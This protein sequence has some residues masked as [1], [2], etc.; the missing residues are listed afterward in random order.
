MHIRLVLVGLSG[1]GKSTLA[2]TIAAKLDWLAIDIDTAI[3]DRMGKSIPE[4]FASEGE[5]GFRQIE[6]EILA[7]SL[8]LDHVVIATGGGAVIREDV[9]TAEMLADSTTLVVHLDAHPAIIIERLMAQ[10]A[11]DGTKAARP[12]LANG[13]PRIKLEQQRNARERYYRRAD[14]SLD[15]GGR[16][17]GAIADDL[18]ELVTLAGGIPSRV[19]LRSTSSPS[20][21]EVGPGSR[22]L[23]GKAIREEWPKARR[24]WVCVDSNLLLHLNE[25]AQEVLGLEGLD[26]QVLDIPAGET[27][28]TVAGLSRIW[29]WLLKC[30]VDRSDV[31]I[32]LG[33]GVVGDLAGF[34]AATV[35]RGIRFVQV[36][37]TLLAMVDS[38]VGGKTGINHASGKNLIGAFYQPAR[39]VIDT[40][41]LATLPER[42]F[43]SGWAE[44]IKHGVIE[45][46]TPNGE[47]DVLLDILERNADALLRKESP[48]LSWVVRRNISLKAAVVEADE[49]EANMRAILNF[50]HTIGHGI[51]A[52]GYR[53]F[54]GE[55]V[56]VGMVAALRIAVLTG[57]VEEARVQR[58]VRLIDAYGLPTSA[59]VDPV[60][61]RRHMRHDKKKA[62]GKQL[63]VLPGPDGI[64]T[65]ETDIDSPT[66]DMAIES[67]V[68]AG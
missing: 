63:W 65:T 55:A 53:L 18:V 59:S 32:A 58:I 57:R 48:L 38:S 62:G 47:A 11:I 35:L 44:V 41:L 25:T 56:A 52:S 36:P 15:V 2:R 26:A 42:E 43:R 24:V 64:V 28:K 17:V 29:D 22:R 10:A 50:G 66:I 40:E 60:D 68:V 33:G 46:S 14:V 8:T 51:E 30:D 20:R 34:A 45:A 19:D 27:S 7:E 21:I 9:W 67:V 6:R 31:L 3:E 49:R 39:V 61:V 37:T 5:D 13:D 12:L 54:H 23:V 1:T 16:L 4:I